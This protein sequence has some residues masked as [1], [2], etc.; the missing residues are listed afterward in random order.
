MKMM[1]KILVID[2]EKPVRDSFIMGLEETEYEVTP[3]E[4]GYQGLEAL[5]SGHY[6]LVYL[7][8]KMPG[9]NGVD[10]LKKIRKKDPDI[11][12]YLVTAYYGDFEDQLDHLRQE[13][14]NFEVLIKP[15]GRQ[16]IIEITQSI[17]DGPVIL[18]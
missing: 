1:K 5:E 13:N 6:D 9:I 11:P 12:V 14:T 7:D 3:C 2:D 17:V 10:T 18:T 16:Q 15:L 4:N 8:L